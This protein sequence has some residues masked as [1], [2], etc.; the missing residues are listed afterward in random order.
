VRI[1]HLASEYPPIQVFGLGR[2]VC[3][4]AVAQAGLGEEV[5]VVT[6]S[7]GG[8]QQEA[9]VDGVAV[10]R[11]DFPPPPKPPDDTMAVQQFNV[12]C[13]ESAVR[14]C[15][16][17]GAPDVIHV[18]DWLTVLAGAEAKWLYPEAR[19]VTTIHDTAQGKYFGSLT[20]PQQYMAHLERWAGMCSDRVICCSRHVGREMVQGYGCPEEKLAIIPCGVDESRFSVK[21][22]LQQFRT[23]FASS[24]EQMLLYVGRLDP[25]KGLPVLLDAMAQVIGIC[26]R[27]KLVI[28]GKGQLQA[29]LQEQM[30]T[31]NL[32]DRAQFAGYLTG[33]ALA[34]AFKCADVLVVPSLYE[35]FGIVALEGMVNRVPVIVADS[36]GL[37]EIVE[38]GRTGLKVPP[39]DPRALAQA[40]VRL[41]WDEPLRRQ[42]GET[43]YE[44]A[45]SRYRWADVARQTVGAYGVCAVPR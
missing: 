22:D 2:A 5:H 3:D 40:I 20:M 37:A 23:M 24:D 10:H 28:V 43:G 13:L 1:V 38:D 9:V 17:I 33:A 29:Q 34:G 18:H 45:V 6:N 25:E 42:L 8:D 4:L 35:P 7:I 27:A 16:R 32:R 36:G 44:Q 26:P 21:G 31:L 15:E 12:S 41:L 14:L 30:R 39:R 19:L 11:I